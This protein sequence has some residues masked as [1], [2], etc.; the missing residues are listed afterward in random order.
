MFKALS[1][2]CGA[3]VVSGV[4][5]AGA[6]G[7][8]GDYVEARTADVF[9]GPCFS[10][11][12]VFIYGKQA[13]MAWKVTEGSYNGVELNGLSVAAALQASTTLSE[14][15]P[16]QARAVIIVD[17]NASVPQREALIAMARELGG[18]RLANVVDVKTSQ[19]RL[20]VEAHS[21]ADADESHAAHGMPQAPRASFWAA[22]LAQIVTRPL[23]ENDHFCGNEVV[24]YSPLSKGV[25][26]VPAYTL[27]NQYKGQGLESKWDDPN[28][29]SS[30][31]GR[32]T[33]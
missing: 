26:A 18:N 31:V 12:E 24:A 6:A 33:L 13:I 2:L 10:N 21:M 17:A 28:C 23:D 16:D 5:V 15:K 20:K 27:G 3:L 14:D 9:T 30:Y 22:N 19:I 1:A 29:R 4:S 11:A 32:F 8:R 7:I 25:V